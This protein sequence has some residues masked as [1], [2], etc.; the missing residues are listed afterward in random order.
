LV[1]SY[2][3]IP[4]STQK[5]ELTTMQEID[6][7]VQTIN[8]Y[9][10]EIESLSEHLIPTTPPKV[11]EQRKQQAATQMEEMEQQVR[12]VA[13]LFDKAVQL[14]KKQEEDQQVEQWDQEEEN[15]SATMQDLK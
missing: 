5:I 14:W 1:V 13:D 2:D 9:R 6:Q 3:K 7:I 4:K 10:Q 8:Q 15:I 11:K 12:A